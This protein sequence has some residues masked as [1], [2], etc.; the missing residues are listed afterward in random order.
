MVKTDQSSL[1]FLL[2]QREVGNE[3]QKW[4]T[5]IMGFSFEILYNPGASNRVADALSRRETEP[6][7][8]NAICST[9]LVDWGTIDKEVEQDS[10][11]SG[12]KQKIQAG[13]EVMHGFT[14]DGG[15]LFYKGR[16]VLPRYTSFIPTL[17]KQYHDSPT[18]GHA[19]E[20]KTYARIARDWFWEG[21]KKQIVEYVK[22]CVVCQ[23]QQ[24][25]SLAPAGLLQPLLI[26][27]Q[28]WEHISMDFIEGLPKSRGKDAILVVVDRLTKYAHFIA[29]KHPFTAVT[30]ADIFVKEIVR[31]HGFP[32]SII[33]DRDEIFMSHFWQEMLRLHTTTLK[34]SMAYHPQTDGQTEV[35]NKT[36]E[37]YLRCFI[38]G[39][40]K[41]WLSWLHWAE[42][43]YNT[44][45]HSST[46]VSPFQ[47]LYGRAS[48]LLNRV[49]QGATA[50]GS[51]EEMRNWMNSNF[52]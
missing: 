3:Y 41:K 49:G 48:P 1:K 43:S 30:V 51:L 35:V 46:Q 50:V 16:F 40:P 37:T 33:S 45:P 36:L 14:L 44:S 7:E 42:F 8:L 32:T 2:E 4:L 12:I 34:S 39:Q 25:S 26:P 18:G 9:Y 47:A 6:V 13:E 21:M 19:G 23:H 31:L 22:K 20:H 11:L 52:N 10:M 38:N 17:L 5:K 29:L 28:V 24:H 15:H 27:D